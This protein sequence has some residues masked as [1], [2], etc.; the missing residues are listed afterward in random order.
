MASAAL[1][2]PVLAA[3]PVVYRTNQGPDFTRPIR[4]LGG[5]RTRLGNKVSTAEREGIKMETIKSANLVLR[6][7]LELCALVAIG[8][9]SFYVAGS[10]ASKW[11]LGIGAP[12]LV[13]VVLAT[14]GA[15]TSSAGLSDT[16]KLRPVAAGL[17]AGIEGTLRVLP[18]EGAY[19]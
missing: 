15:P 6:F 1:T 4:W 8:Y 14:F 19:A 11:I 16:A 2:R 17:R 9:W 10:S 12:L 3:L 5:R 7:V 18:K 13:A